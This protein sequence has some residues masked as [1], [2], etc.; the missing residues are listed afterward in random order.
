LK[1]DAVILLQEKHPELALNFKDMSAVMLT[2]RRLSPMEIFHHICFAKAMWKARC[3]AIWHTD[4]MTPHLICTFFWEVVG[5]HKKPPPTLT[6]RDL[7]PSW[8][9]DRWC[10][11]VQRTTV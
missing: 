10:I 4:H 1:R 5:R 6:V 11:N 8:E 2:H 3:A 9:V 7:I